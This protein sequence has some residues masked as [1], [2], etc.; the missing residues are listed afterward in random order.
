[1]PKKGSDLQ[2]PER[3]SQLACSQIGY[4]SLQL[5]T[6]LRDPAT[7]RWVTAGLWLTSKARCPANAGQCLVRWTAVMQA[8]RMLTQ[9]DRWHTMLDVDSQVCHAVGL[10]TRH[11]RPPLAGILALAPPLD[12]ELHCHRLPVV[13]ALA[14]S[15]QGTACRHGQVEA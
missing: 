13:H 9:L 8:L 4:P 5:Q 12:V 1:M 15:K 2:Q 14:E 11:S 3:C 10:I 7:R 6:R